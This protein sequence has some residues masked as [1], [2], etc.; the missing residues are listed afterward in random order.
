M[1]CWPRSGT[2]PSRSARFFVSV[3]TH[4]SAFQKYA[5]SRRRSLISSRRD[6]TLLPRNRSRRPEKR[7]CLECRCRRTCEIVGGEQNERLEQGD[8]ADPGSERV[9]KAVLGRRQARRSGTATLPE[10]RA[11]P[12]PAL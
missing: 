3:S 5:R 2:T 12:A 10:L 9:D 1:A 11:F 7:C 4:P 6:R 8:P